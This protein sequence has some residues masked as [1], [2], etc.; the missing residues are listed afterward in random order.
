MSIIVALVTSGLF[1]AFVFFGVV[2]M[3]VYIAAVLFS[4]EYYRV[5]GVNLIVSLGCLVVL[6]VLS[7]IVKSLLEVNLP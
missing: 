5:A 2:A 3:I 6:V 7:S 4:G 1:L